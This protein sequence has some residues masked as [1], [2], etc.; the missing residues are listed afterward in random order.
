MKRYT[1]DEDKVILKHVKENSSNLTVAFEKAALELG[2]TT[3][4]VAQRWYNK[5]SKSNDDCFM[6]IGHKKTTL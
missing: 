3:H 4:G 1:K 5:L 2:R 6:C